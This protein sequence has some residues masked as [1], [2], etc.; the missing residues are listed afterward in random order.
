MME[1]KHNQYWQWG[2]SE[3]PENTKLFQ[4]IGIED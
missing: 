3:R 2:V 1:I 4:L